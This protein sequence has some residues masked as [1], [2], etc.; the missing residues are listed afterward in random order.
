[1]WRCRLHNGGSAIPADVLPH[2]F[3]IFFSTKPGGTGI[4]LPL[5]QRI[6]EEHGGTIII[7]SAPEQGTSATILL[8][9]LNG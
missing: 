5:C 1:M 2:V 6:I 9:L 7:E 8:P 3:E 4:G